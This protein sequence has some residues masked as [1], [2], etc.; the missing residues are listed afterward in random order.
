MKLIDNASKVLRQAWSVRLGIVA[1]LL[2]GA[3]VIVPLFADAV[4]RNT[5]ALL[6]FVTA[7]G[8]VVARFVAQPRIHDGD[9]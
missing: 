6:S 5:F 4:P 7:M 9:E 3:E 1:G 8:A 2:S